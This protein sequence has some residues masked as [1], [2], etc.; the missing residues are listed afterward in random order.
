MSFGEKAAALKKDQRTEA[1]LLASTVRSLAEADET[2]NRV[3]TTLHGQTE[4]LHRIKA[5]SDS[6]NDNLNQSEWLLRSLK[7]MGWFRNI[8][9][10]DPVITSEKT[11]APGPPSAP[12]GYAGGYP[13]ESSKGA[14]RLMA[15]DAARRASRNSTSAS[16]AKT[17]LQDP[18]EKAL[19]QID[20]MLEGLRDK[21]LQ[22]NKTLS[23]HNEMLPEIGRSVERDQDRIKKQ[24]EEIRKRM[25]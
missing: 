12:G 5:D 20:H 14:A 19:D 24:N 10:K 16:S 4:Q 6:I 7:P 15:D 18:N 3:L 21:S 23:H 25:R 13:A 17:E 8:F 9:R 2:T 11:S 22:I 1:E